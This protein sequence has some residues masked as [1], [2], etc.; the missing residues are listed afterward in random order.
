MIIKTD[1]HMSELLVTL[2]NY[3]FFNQNSH[4]SFAFLYIS[5][6]YMH[7]PPS[8]PQFY[9]IWNGSIFYSTE[10]CNKVNFSCP[11]N[12]STYACT[13]M[14]YVYSV[15]VRP[16]PLVFT[17]LAMIFI[18]NPLKY[19]KV[20]HDHILPHPLQFIITQSFDTTV[21]ITDSIIK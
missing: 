7:L 16:K 15:C 3:L 1:N 13:Y 14:Q 4:C 6:R 12:D 19:V 11:E 2:L 18:L 5:D 8:Y 9:E 20:G 17:F 10:K 21:R